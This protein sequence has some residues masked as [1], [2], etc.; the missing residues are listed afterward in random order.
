MRDRHGKGHGIRISLCSSGLLAFFCGALRQ[1]S[2][3]R[4]MSKQRDMRYLDVRE[5]QLDEAEA[6][7]LGKQASELPGELM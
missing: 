3:A 2:L 5:D 1:S 4:R 6:R 7:R